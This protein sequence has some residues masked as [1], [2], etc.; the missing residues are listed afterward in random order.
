LDIFNMFDK[1]LILNKGQINYFGKAKDTY[2]Y[3]RELGYTVP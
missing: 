2:Q 1:L 3:Y